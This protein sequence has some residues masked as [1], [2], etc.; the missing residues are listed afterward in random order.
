[1][2]CEFVGQ[3]APRGTPDWIQFDAKK[4]EAYVIELISQRLN[5][6]TDP[7]FLLQRVVKNDK[8]EEQVS[9][10]TGRTTARRMSVRRPLQPDVERSGVRFEVPDDGTYRVL[11]RDLYAR[12]DA[13]D[14]YRLSIRTPAPISGWWP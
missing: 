13:R 4:G 7:Y 10:V 8:G 3:F 5:L 1:M 2:P 14:V 11:V 12:D 6:A 9:D